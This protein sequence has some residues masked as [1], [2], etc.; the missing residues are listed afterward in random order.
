[1]IAE[2]KVCSKCGKEKGLGEFYKHSLTRDRH[3][4]NCKQCRKL[5]G[6]KYHYAHKEKA[7]ARSKAWNKNHARQHK[8]LQIHKKFGISLEEYEFKL[9]QQGHR[10]WI[11]GKTDRESGQ[12]FGLDHDHLS[13]KN[14]AFLCRPC[15]VT[16]GFYEKV[17]R[18]ALRRRIEDYLNAFK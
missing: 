10:C 9:A 15:N 16:V 4:P 8:E 1:M 7:N 3:E 18:T 17:V 14:R 13:G 11:C 6:Q 5:Y 12:G 2:T